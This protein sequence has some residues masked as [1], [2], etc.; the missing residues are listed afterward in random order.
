MVRINLLAN[1]F[2]YDEMENND[3][4]PVVLEAWAHVSKANLDLT[5][6]GDGHC[7][8]IRQCSPWRSYD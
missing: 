6:R 8:N 2:R 4:A 1:R 7:L 3:W 5:I